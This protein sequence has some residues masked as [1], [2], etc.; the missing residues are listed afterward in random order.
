[1][2]EETFLLDFQFQLESPHTPPQQPHNSIF[3]NPDTPN[4]SSSSSSDNEDGP[5]I[6]IVPLDNQPPNNMAQAAVSGGQLS[7]IAQYFGNQGLS[8]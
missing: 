2:N 1:M 6:Q 4:P 7:S 3:H 5:P 8:C